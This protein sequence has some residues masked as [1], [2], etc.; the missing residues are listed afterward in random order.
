MKPDKNKWKK[1]R[2]GDICTL[3]YGKSLKEEKRNGG[4][5]PV[6]GSAGIVG[7][8]D[9]ALIKLPSLIIGRK[10]SIGNNFYSECPCFPIDTVYYIIDCQP[11]VILKWLQIVIS[12]FDIKK[13]NMATAIPGINRNIINDI[14]IPLP[15]LPE[16]RQIVNL[17]QNIENCIEQAE[18][19]EKNLKALLKKLV[20]DLTQAQPKFGNL[21]TNKNCKSVLFNEISDCIE[22]H[23]KKKRNK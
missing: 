1:V 20:D 16:Q 2:L 18:Q 15:P 3:N 4:N 5:I 19:Q 8:H 9:Y 23:D 10:G 14:I 22:K 7:W 13:L 12:H 21:L 11:N 6:Y 17:F